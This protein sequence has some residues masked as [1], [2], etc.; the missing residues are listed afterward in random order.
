MIKTNAM[1][2]LDQKNIVYKTIEYKVDEKD[3]NGV[4]IAKQIG[5]PGEQLFKTLV[6]YG[7]KKGYLVFNIPVNKDL[8]LKQA[9]F[10]IGD[11]KIEM[12]PTKDL[13]RVTGYIRGGCSPIGMKKKYPLFL[14][15]SVLL[16]KEIGI[17]AGIRGCQ[18]ILDPKD[19]ICYMNA[20]ILKLTRENS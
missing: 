14:D 10:L 11:K 6:T 12:I 18:I 15:E 13:L 5:M 2:L 16:Y 19:L 7:E 9:A 3:L 17:S 20:K 8:D 1:R 4:H